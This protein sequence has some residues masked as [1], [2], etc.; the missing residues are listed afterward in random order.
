MSDASARISPTRWA[1]FEVD[2]SGL[3]GVPEGIIGCVWLKRTATTDLPGWVAAK[4]DHLGTIAPA[5]LVAWLEATTTRWAPRSTARSLKAL[6]AKV[7][8]AL[9]KEGWHVVPDDPVEVYA[10]ELREPA[11]G[12]RTRLYVGETT[13][14]P[15][16]LAEHRGE[17]EDGTPGGRAV[18]RYGY[19]RYRGD[20][21]E[22]VR[23]VPTALRKELEAQVS[24]WLR[25][26][27]FEVHGDGVRRRPTSTAFVPG[28]SW[29]E[30]LAAYEAANA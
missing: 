16:R 2:G 17:V 21:T 30:L 11:P 5:P 20:L 25:R 8:L 7:V 1:V 12:G 27:G 13:D 29:D 10:I 26:R 3:A 9:T 22:D 14:L 6:R 4:W 18:V 19:G 23:A 28:I 15:K 24:A